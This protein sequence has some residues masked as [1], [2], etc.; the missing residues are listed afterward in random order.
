MTP[1]QKQVYE[2]AKRNLSVREIC[3][4]TGLSEHSVRYVGYRLCLTFRSSIKQK[5]PVPVRQPISDRRTVIVRTTPT[6]SASVNE[7]R[8][9]V[10]KMP[11]DESEGAIAPR[12]ETDPRFSLVRPTP[13]PKS[14]GELV[15]EAL[16]AEL[17]EIRNG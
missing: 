14:R 4:A 13:A 5:A 11:W 3:R 1:V 9:S 10:S 17:A 7:S 16:R 8:V 6:G 2:L 12:P 15:I